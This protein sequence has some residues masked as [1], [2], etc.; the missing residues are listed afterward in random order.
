[1]DA[2]PELQQPAVRGEP[3]SMGAVQWLLALSLSALAA[4]TIALGVAG[5]P[6]TEE[7]LSR[8]QTPDDPRAQVQAMHALI[9]RG[10]WEEHPLEELTRHLESSSV[11]VRDFVTRMH[12]SLL[13]P[14]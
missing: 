3:S 13:R 11:E 12:G 8:A 2:D 6:S 4:A 1:M 9:L 14:R 5:T 10:Y 7:L